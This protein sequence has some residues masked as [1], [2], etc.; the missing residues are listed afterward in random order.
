MEIPNLLSIFL[1]LHIQKRGRLAGC[2][3]GRLCTSSATLSHAAGVAPGRAQGATVDGLGPV[4]GPAGVASDSCVNINIDWVIDDSVRF[5]F[6]WN[7]DEFGW[8]SLVILP[9]TINWPIM[10]HP[11]QVCAAT[12]EAEAGQMALST[13]RSAGLLVSTVMVYLVGL[14]IMLQETILALPLIH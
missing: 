6:L 7:L 5:E 14:N 9:R 3:R 8:F 2:L 4:G 10:A 12:H 13:G 11:W 1:G